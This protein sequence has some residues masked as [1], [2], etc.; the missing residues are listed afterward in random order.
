MQAPSEDAWTFDT[1]GL[2]HLP[3]TL[4]AEQLDSAQLGSPEDAASPLRAHPALLHAIPELG[5]GETKYRLDAPARLLPAAAS[6]QQ[7]WGWLNSDAVQDVKRLGYDIVVGQPTAEHDSVRRAQVRGFRVLWVLEDTDAL[8]SVTGSHKGSLPP[9]TPEVAASMK[10]LVP[11]QL[12]AGDLVL[13]SA[14]TLLSWMPGAGAAPPKILELVLRLD[15]KIGSVR[16]S[17]VPTPPH[18][19]PHTPH[20]TSLIQPSCRLRSPTRSRL[21]R[22]GPRPPR[23]TLR[24]R[25]I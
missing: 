11:L 7:R 16:S 14:T 25:R 9:P 18:P 4:T 6:P 1:T 17:P 20:P 21:A 23:R 22:R 12:R 15:S 5:C 2:L 10:A 3:G 24:S 13:A 19:T 8:G